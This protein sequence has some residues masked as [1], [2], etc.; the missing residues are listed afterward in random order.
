MPPKRL[1]AVKKEFNTM[2]AQGI[3]RPSDSPWSSP[4]H[5][6][7]KQQEGEW[8][9]CGDFL[10][11]NA[12]T[13]P[14]RYPIPQVQ[15]FHIKLQGCTVFSKVDLVRAFH[16]IHVAPENVKTAITT[17]FGAF[18]FPVMNLGLRNAAK[19]FQRFMDRVLRDMPWAVVY[20]DDILVASRD[21]QEHEEHLHLLFTCL[22]QFGLKVHH[23]KCVLG[24]HQLDFLG[25]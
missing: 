15:D 9:V 19:T 6:V 25:H 16:Q 10:A 14:D 5:M 8:R 11:L 7:P 3:T 4:L 22:Q 12:A 2:V 17:P 21:V 20:I 18:E 13:V 1:E 24:A 23:S